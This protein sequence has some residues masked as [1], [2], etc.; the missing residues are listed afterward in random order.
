MQLV[1]EAQFLIIMFFLLFAAAST[2]AVFG[3]V[4]VALTS[5]YASL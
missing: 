3:T 5:L 1:N 2:T 4:T